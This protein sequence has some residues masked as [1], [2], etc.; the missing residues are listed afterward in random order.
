MVLSSKVTANAV[1]TK[2]AN[3]QRFHQS[4]KLGATQ[5]GNHIVVFTFLNTLELKLS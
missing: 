1:S 5:I 3:M 2:K 4:S